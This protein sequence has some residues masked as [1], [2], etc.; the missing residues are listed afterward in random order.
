MNILIPAILNVIALLACGAA[1]WV[2]WENHKAPRIN[3]RSSKLASELNNNAVFR[4]ADKIP[5]FRRSGNASVVDLAKALGIVLV[6]SF[7]PSIMLYAHSLDVI[8]WASAILLLT[9]ACILFMHPALSHR[10]S[11]G[12][13]A[14]GR[15]PFKK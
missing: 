4:C 10:Q 11:F 14:R 9:I 3:N 12:D 15:S 6:I 13:N 7:V 8:L 1:L 2:G 5:F